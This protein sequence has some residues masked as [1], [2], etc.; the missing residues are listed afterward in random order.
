VVLSGDNAR[1]REL[2][3]RYFDDI[4]IKD[5]VKRYGVK[6]IHKLEN[7]A[8]LLV[9]TRATLQAFNKLKERIGASLVTVEE[10][11]S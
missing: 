6:E 7:L 2:L 3:L 11:C 9:A 8:N 5:M 10:L 4:I 1:K